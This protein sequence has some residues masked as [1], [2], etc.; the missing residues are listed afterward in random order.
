RSPTLES[1]QGGN[2]GPQ[3]VGGTAQGCLDEQR[4][5]S[6]PDGSLPATGQ[7][8][9]AVAGGVAVEPGEAGVEGG[10]ESVALGSQGE[11]GQAGRLQVGRLTGGVAPA[12]LVVGLGRQLVAKCGEVEHGVSPWG[13]G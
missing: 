4:Q 5:G 11:Q 7:P 10:A 8:I 3:L 9:G 12:A 6:R 13:R 1:E 2:T